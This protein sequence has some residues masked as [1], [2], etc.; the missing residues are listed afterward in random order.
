MQKIED[1]PR[2]VQR[3]CGGWLAHA[4][5]GDSLQIGAVGVSADDATQAYHAAVVAWSANI[6]R[7]RK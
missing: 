3:R 6:A 7:G 2:L 1:G 4:N 5:R